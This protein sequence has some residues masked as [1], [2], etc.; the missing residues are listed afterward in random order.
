MMQTLGVM[1]EIGITDPSGK[2]DDRPSLVEV[3]DQYR[4]Y[5]SV[6]LTRRKY[7]IDYRVAR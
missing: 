7:C 4:Y 3:V 6:L 1:P 5:T 2:L